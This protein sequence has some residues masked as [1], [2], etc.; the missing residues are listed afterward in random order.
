MTPGA[1]LQPSL[2]G[3]KSLSNASKCGTV[4]ILGYKSTYMR[5]QKCLEVNEDQIPDF[6]LNSHLISVR[7]NKRLPP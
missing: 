2:V 3:L 1:L 6:R 7:M 4:Y 5:V